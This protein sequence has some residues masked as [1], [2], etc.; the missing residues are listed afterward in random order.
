MHLLRVYL[1]WLQD[2]A[3]Q[4]I[5]TIVDLC[6]QINPSPRGVLVQFSYECV[7]L[8]VLFDWKVCS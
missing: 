7:H 4:L 2:Q 5:M 1:G 8:G 6:V 3:K